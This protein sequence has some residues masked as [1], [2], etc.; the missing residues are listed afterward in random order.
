M[1]TDARPSMPRFCIV[2]SA[3][4]FPVLN[5]FHEWIS[6]RRSF[7]KPN[8]SPNSQ[9]L[10]GNIA[11]RAVWLV[12][13]IVSQQ[14]ENHVTHPLTWPYFSANNGWKD[15]PFRQR[16]ATEWQTS[17]IGP[18]EVACKLP[19]P[20]QTK[21]RWPRRREVTLDN[22]GNDSRDRSR[23]PCNQRD[24]EN[25]GIP[26]SLQRSKQKLQRES[27]VSQSLEFWV[28][29]GEGFLKAFWQVLKAGMSTSIR[30]QTTKHG[31]ASH[32]MAQKKTRRTIPSAGQTTGTLF[33]DAEACMLVQFLP[34]MECQRRSLSS[35]APETASLTVSDFQ[36]RRPSAGD[37]TPSTLQSALTPSVRDRKVWDA[38]PAPCHQ[39]G[40]LKSHPPLLT[41]CLNGVLQQGVCQTSKKV[42]KVNNNDKDFFY[43][44]EH[45]A[46]IWLTWNDFLLTPA[47]HC[48]TNL[49]MSFSTAFLSLRRK[50]VPVWLLGSQVQISLGAW[51][52]V[53]CVC[54]CR[55]STGLCDGPITHPQECYR[56][57]SLILCNRMQK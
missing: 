57:C 24:D 16:V 29:E 13:S 21:N 6:I 40:S 9:K 49:L 27:I 4:D 26:E 42:A 14:T 11:M 15:E 17:P 56:L 47:L 18:P 30:K 53:S 51:M 22:H 2:I 44:S 33:W 38:R 35:D 54:S 50:S 52:F 34:Q 43:R 37:F 8:A 1:Q 3:P 20:R 39:E 10:S 7:R 25:F 12:P 46:Q 31:M 55:V 32:N 45:S 23:A 5:K 41:K 19:L 48:E 36:E 28:V